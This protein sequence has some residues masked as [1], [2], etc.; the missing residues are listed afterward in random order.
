MVQMKNKIAVLLMEAGVSYNKQRLHKTGYFRGLLA[1]RIGTA[2]ERPTHV[3]RNSKKNCTGAPPEA[4]QKSFCPLDK[5]LS[6]KSAY[7]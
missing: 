7:R 4:R 5:E 1:T 2:A 6:W 3:A